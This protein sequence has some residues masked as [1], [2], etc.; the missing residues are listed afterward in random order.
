MELEET[1]KLQRFIVNL[2]MKINYS[3][4]ILGLKIIFFLLY[5]YIC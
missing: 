3:K 5:N 1:K 2:V 4:I